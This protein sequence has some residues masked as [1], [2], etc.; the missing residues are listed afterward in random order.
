ML[1]GGFTG[2]LGMVRHMNGELQHT[3]WGVTAHQMCQNKAAND[4]G[5]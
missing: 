2:W 4:S 3:G 1:K 5:R